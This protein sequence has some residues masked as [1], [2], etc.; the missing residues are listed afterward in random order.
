MN[1]DTHHGGQRRSLW[2]GPAAVAAIFLSL[3]VAASWRIDDWHWPPQAFVVVG[4]LV[5]TLGVVYQWV[6][7]RWD[8]CE[9]RAA[10]G[11]AFVAGFILL[12]GNFVQMADVNPLA[13]MY[14]AV[15]VVGLVGTAVARLRPRGMARAL[16]VTALAQISV[17]AVLVVLLMLRK[18][19]VTTWT[20]PEWRGFFGNAMNGLMFAASAL[21]FRK[22]DHRETPQGS[23]L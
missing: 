11:I 7:R 3:L 9:Y 15:P 5:F 14:F 21:L 8:T 13:A 10:V 6:T 1:S 2:K 12:W 18:P 20:P 19:E 4:G 23:V 16:G 17:L 22:A